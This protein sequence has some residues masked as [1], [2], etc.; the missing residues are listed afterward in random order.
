MKYILIISAIIALI[1]YTFLVIWCVKNYRR[2]VR[3]EK[4]DEN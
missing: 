3:K 4:E 2:A 1:A